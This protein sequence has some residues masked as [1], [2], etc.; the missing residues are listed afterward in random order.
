MSLRNELDSSI[1]PSSFSIRAQKSQILESVMAKAKGRA[2]GTKVTSRTYRGAWKA[3]EAGMA[4]VKEAAK[5]AK[6]TQGQLLDL[7]VAGYLEGLTVPQMVK[8]ATAAHFMMQE[9]ALHAQ[10]AKLEEARAAALKG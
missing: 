1:G 4:K 8:A 6:L 2:K 5:E 10:M 7:L 9:K 3:D